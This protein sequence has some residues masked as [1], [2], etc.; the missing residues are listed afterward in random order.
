MSG[1][2][3]F[4]V[5]L[6]TDLTIHEVAECARTAD[7]CGFSHVTFVDLNSVSRDVNFMMAV[8]ALN[9]SRIQIGQGVTEPKTNH[10]AA[11]RQR[12]RDV[13]LRLLTGGRAF[14]GIGAGGPWGRRTLTRGA[15]IQELREAVQFI[16]RYSAGEDADWERANLALG[17]D[18][19]FLLG[20]P[21]PY[22][23]TW[24]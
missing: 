4:G 1:R 10:P 3:Q 8:A 17:V 14:V 6:G 5:G 16:K 12:Y 7:Q 9:T 20:R 22:R 24:A 13:A 21:G 19:E 11:D 23:F 18:P 2:I 15:K